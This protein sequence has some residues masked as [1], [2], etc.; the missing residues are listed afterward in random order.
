[1]KR[2]TVG[3]VGAGAVGPALATLLSRAGWTIGT[4]ASRSAESAR[5]AVRLV[6]AGSASVRNSDAAEGADLLLIAVPDAAVGPVAE[7]LARSGKVAAGTL[8][9]HLSGALS[10]DVLEPL[11]RSG[12]TTGSLHP[13]QSFAS[14]E[15]AIERL[16][17][18]WIF[19]EG[20]EPERIRAIATDLSS[21]N[22]PLAR[23][24]KVLYHAGAAAACNLFVSMVDLGVKLMERA[25]ISRSDALSALLP[26]VEGTTRNLGEVGL[27][28]ALTGP[29]ARGDVETVRGHLRAISTTAPELLP[30]YREATRH[31]VIVGLEKGTLAPEAAE[32]IRSVLDGITPSR[33]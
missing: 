7:E 12:A 25:G 32:R 23:E 2:G 31:A 8:V 1:V 27:P 21:R 11:R 19:Y 22:A 30:A 10:S 4:I 6:G 14:A 16:S 3:I 24:A 5:A 29:V 26:L 33:G 13:L 17:D 28:R 15:T 9:L 20:E 18:A